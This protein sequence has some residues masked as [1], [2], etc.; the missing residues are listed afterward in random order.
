MELGVVVW[1]QSRHKSYWALLLTLSIWIRWDLKHVVNIFVKVKQ[2]SVLC[3]QSPS[4]SHPGPPVWPE[5]R[6]AVESG[7]CGLS[8]PWRDPA[9]QDTLD[10]GAGHGTVSKAVL[11]QQKYTHV[12][13]NW[14]YFIAWHHR[15]L[16]LLFFRDTEGQPQYNF[17]KLDQLIELLWVNRLQPGTVPPS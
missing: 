3:I 17:T 7:L 14:A 4:P 10:A 12:K 8:S 16:I 13:E 9:G 5:H 1:N 11:K 2:D 15:C 6:P